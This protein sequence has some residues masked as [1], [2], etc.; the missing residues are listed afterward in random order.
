MIRYPGKW[1]IGRRGTS[2]GCRGFCVVDRRLAGPELDEGP[3][4]GEHRWWSR[5]RVLRQVQEMRNV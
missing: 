2:A 3:N 4:T 1:D 5:I